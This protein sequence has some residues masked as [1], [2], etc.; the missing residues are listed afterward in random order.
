[1]PISNH[2]IGHWGTCPGLILVYSHLNLLIQKDNLNMIFVTGPGHGAPAL[3][4]SLWLEGSI[5]KF[6]PDISMSKAGLE[7]LVSGFS[8]PGGFPSHINAQTPGAIHEGGE[9]GY[10]LAVAFG[11]IMDKPEL[12]VPVVIGDGEAETGPTATAWHGY[13]FIDPKESGAVIPIVHLNGFKISERTIYGCMSNED[14]IMLFKGL[15]Y[16][17]RVVQNLEK[18]DDEL[19]ET[20]VWAIAE[21]RKIQKSAREGKPI[22]EPRWPMIILRSPKVGDIFVEREHG[23]TSFRDGDV[24]RKLMVTYW[25]APIK[26]IKSLFQRLL[27]T[28]TI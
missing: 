24:L 15:G 4:A 23:L 5:S 17:P 19:H 26:A 13:K 9:L 21:I 14:L 6:Y 2:I 20:L 10:A 12:I 1:M 7:K 22:T 28:K 8:T 16:Q 18:I 25:K 27:P 11:A 3:L